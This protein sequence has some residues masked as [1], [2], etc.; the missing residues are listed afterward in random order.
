MSF[1]L[2]EFFEN[3]GENIAPGVAAGVAGLLGALMA[4][5][6]AVALIIGIGMYVFRSMGLYT[7]AKRRGLR[8][9]GMAWVPVGSDWLVGSI[10]DQYNRKARRTNLHLR[11][12][13][14]IGG[15]VVL[16]VQIAQ[17]VFYAVNIDQAM[18]EMWMKDPEM[19]FNESEMWFE[20]GEFLPLISG[21][22]ISSLI[23]MVTTAF[24]VFYYIALFR[25]Y[26][27]GTAGRP[28]WMLILSIVLGAA[29][30]SVILFCIRRK[31]DGFIELQRR[32][33]EEYGYRSGL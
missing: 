19:W 18:L 8:L 16:A 4:V 13:L 10:A 7:I 30:E 5:V 28:V 29:A 11:T 1:D 33:Q 2:F 14:L 17:I 12:I 26:R 3:F 25:V 20:S 15:F 31:D 32:E 22:S 23:S 6:W 9:P 21:M 27:A 24:S